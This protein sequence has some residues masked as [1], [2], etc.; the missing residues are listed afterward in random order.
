MIYC[1]SNPLR[2][3]DFKTFAITEGDP[4]VCAVQL[5]NGTFQTHVYAVFVL[6]TE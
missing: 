3:I 6:K 4:T 5:L 2:D 1:I